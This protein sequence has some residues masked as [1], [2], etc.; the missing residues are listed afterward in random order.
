MNRLDLNDIPLPRGLSAVVDQAV[1]NARDDKPVVR[2][3]FRRRC[4][5][6][7]AI[8]LVGLAVVCFSVP[9][10][11]AAIA[12]FFS[13]LRGT[14]LENDSRTS[15]VDNGFTAPVPAGSQ[16]TAASD[17]YQLTLQNYYLDADEIGLDF[18]LSGPELDSPWEMVSLPNL[19]L[20]ITDASGKRQVW[21]GTDI[22]SDAVLTRVGENRYDL[23]VVLDSFQSPVDRPRKE[24]HLTFD[25]IQIFAPHAMEDER[26][27][28]K[29]QHRRTV[30]LRR[31]HR[32]EVRP[33]RYG[34][35]SSRGSRG[36][37]GARDSGEER[38]GQAV[39]HKDRAGL[40]TTQRTIWPM[41]RMFARRARRGSNTRSTS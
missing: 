19:A 2:R 10:V 7:V 27:T 1:K 34:H 16:S 37:V 26:A 40:S 41:K 36:C 33:G 8:G 28:V 38:R 32:R 22:Y 14:S 3:G 29:G 24:M 23:A 25:D 20:E 31:A 15:I 11:T 6:A 12:D 13:S 4:L 39:R 35:L 9:P 18:V 17:C 30:G 5:V 21:G